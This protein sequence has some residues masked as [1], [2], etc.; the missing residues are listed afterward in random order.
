[1]GVCANDVNAIKNMKFEDATELTNITLFSQ[2][3]ILSQP[4]YALG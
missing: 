2:A 3:K 1:M 4:A